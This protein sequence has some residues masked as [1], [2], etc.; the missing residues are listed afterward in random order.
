MVGLRKSQSINTTCFPAFAVWRANK[1]HKVDFPS[2]G[3][4]DVINT[5]FTSESGFS[6]DR[7]ILRVLMASAN[8]ERG[9]SNKY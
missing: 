1:L 8:D 9:L 5:V 4:A 7:E 3:T 6:K 2:P